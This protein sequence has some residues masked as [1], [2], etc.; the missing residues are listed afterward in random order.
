[1]A[2]KLGAY[3]HR[4]LKSSQDIDLE[5]LGLWA[6]TD[7]DLSRFAGGTGFCVLFSG[8]IPGALLPVLG[9]QAFE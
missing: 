2:H 9:A 7:L 3:P 8:P 4:R 6:D 1:M 5:E